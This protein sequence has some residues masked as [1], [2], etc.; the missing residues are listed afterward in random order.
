MLDPRR[1]ERVGTSRPRRSAL[2]RAIALAWAASVDAITVA[3]SPT[4]PPSGFS[5]TA[6]HDLVQRRLSTTFGLFGLILLGVLVLGTIANLVF[7][8]E[9]AVAV[10]VPR[11][12][13]VGSIVVLLG[14]WRI[15]R[16]PRLPWRLLAFVDGATLFAVVALLSATAAYAPAQLRTEHIAGSLFA[17]IVPLRAALVPTPPV[18]TVF[19]SSIAAIPLPITAY[20]TGIA[21]ET[22]GAFPRA[23]G[24]VLV[25]CWCVAATVAGAAIS[26][27]VYGLRVQVKSAMQL[28]DYTLEQKI[29]EGAMGVVYRARHAMLRRPTALKLLATSRS[30]SVAAKRFER[31]VQ[32]TSRLTHPNTIAIYDYGHTRDGIF[33]YAMEYLDGMTLSQVCDESGPQPAGRVIHILSQAARALDEAHSIGLIHRDV[34]PANIFLCVRGGLYDF[35]KVLDFGLVKEVAARETSA[36]ELNMIAGTPL[37]MAPET[38]ARPEEVDLHVDIYALGAVGYFLLTGEPPFKGKSTIEVYH[39]HLYEQP[40]SPSDR[41]GKVVPAELEKLVTACLAKSPRDRPKSAGELADL[42]DVMQAAHPWSK[43]DAKAWWQSCRVPP[44]AESQAVIGDPDLTDALGATAEPGTALAI[45]PRS[46][47]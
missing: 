2:K 29:G 47:P 32:Q 35:V 38:I 45:R 5:S 1:G 3:V 39:A 17:L 27:V 7:V 42:L 15:C 14:A 9:L 46:S 11:G 28:G 13:Y 30:D 44:K 10:D 21:G 18:W 4:E 22:T 16:G 36:S 23:L 24:I 26:R 33:Y 41:L 8:P 6:D 25:V 40:Q 43:A 34:K 37:Y 20:V 12:A 31:E 19:V